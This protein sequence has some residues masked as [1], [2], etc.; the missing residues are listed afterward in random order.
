MTRVVIKEV[1]KRSKK[2]PIWP[3]FANLSHTREDTVLQRKK[4]WD[5]HT[6]LSLKKV[7][8]GDI[9]W[10]IKPENLYKLDSP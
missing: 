5:T 4:I 10:W 8:R 3:D 9:E 7:R 1:S 2:R 6:N